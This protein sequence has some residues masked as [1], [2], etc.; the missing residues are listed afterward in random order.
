ME[1]RLRRTDGCRFAV[2]VVPLCLLA[3][4]TMSTDTFADPET[5]AARDRH[6]EPAITAPLLRQYR[7]L[8]PVEP[9][10]WKPLDARWQFAL[11]DPAEGLNVAPDRMPTRREEVTLP[12]RRLH[13]DTPYWYLTEI[14]IATPSVLSISA[15]DGAQLFANGQRIPIRGD[16]FPVAAA[17][18]KTRL[19]VRVLNKALYGGLE[20]VRIVPRSDFDRYQSALTRRSRL[21]ALVRKVRLLQS[22]TREQVSTV[23]RAVR[24]ETDGSLDTGERLLAA[25]P[26]TV[27]GPYLQ[28]AGSDRMTVVWETDVPCAATLTWSEEGGSEQTLSAVS[29]KN[30]HVVSMTGLRA[31]TTYRYRTRSGGVT[32]REFRFRTLPADGDFAFTVWSDSHA[33]ER[34]G[35]NNE[36]FR[37]NVRAMSRWPIAFSVGTGDLVEQGHRP[38]P[39]RA[40]F[41]SLSPLCAETPVML[42]GGNHDYDGCFEDLRPVH[43]ERYA[44]TRPKPQ[45]YAWTAGNARFV[46]LDPNEHFPT[47]IPAGSEQHR[48]LMR[49]LESADWKQAT[50]RF[51]F[52]HQ[53]P[54]SQGWAEYHGDLPLRELFDPLIEK[55]GIDFIVSGHTHDYERW[56]RTYGRQ[57]VT[58]LIV[59]TAGGGLEE[60]AMS[61]EPVMDRVIRR[62]G[63][64]LFRL[65]GNRVSFEAIATDTRV[66]DRFEASK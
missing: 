37:Q 27:I 41:E 26:L 50:W 19:I 16:Y 12:Q 56:T 22:P 54:Y 61:A 23:E 63:F 59:G 21:D 8:S 7:A 33:N 13:A 66:L 53:P 47:G 51:L 58:F 6:G 11:G 15:D 10:A 44:R 20:G 25:L 32:G 55:Y 14:P 36:V 9:P 4:L 39:W 30:L 34:P 24:D 52:L 49:E 28:D 5:L 18:G 48:W 42:V 38:G 57:R 65:S 31:G 40:F 60:E 35:G 62:H 45:Y 29:E 1:L 46:A 17:E 3:I 43:F 2:I 64:G